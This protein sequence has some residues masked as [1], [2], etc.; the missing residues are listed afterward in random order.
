MKTDRKK[1]WKICLVN[2]LITGGLVPA[3]FVIFAMIAPD[4]RSAVPPFLLITVYSF[5]TSCGITRLFLRMHFKSEMYA[6]LAGAGL[7]LANVA[8]PGMFVLAVTHK[9]PMA[10]GVVS[11]ILILLGIFALIVGACSGGILFRTYFRPD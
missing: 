8:L 4:F 2:G 3:C 7:S 6:W 1:T 10:F 5:I 9:D 11:G